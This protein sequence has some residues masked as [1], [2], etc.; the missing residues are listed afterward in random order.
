[1]LRKQIFVDSFFKRF[2]NSKILVE[3]LM[4]LSSRFHKGLPIK[5]W[6][7]LIQVLV[8]TFFIFNTGGEDIEKHRQQI[9]R[10]HQTQHDQIHCS[11][12]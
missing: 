1:M 4:L 6:Q 5:N 8:H 10:H 7:F 2:L 9:A 3:Y 12:Y 11:F